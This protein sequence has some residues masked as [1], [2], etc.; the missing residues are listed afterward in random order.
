MAAASAEATLVPA[1]AAEAAAAAAE[2]VRNGRWLLHPGWCHRP[3][4]N[5][6]VPVPRVPG[7][8]CIEIFIC[9]RSVL[10]VKI[11]HLF[12]MSLGKLVRP[13][14]QRFTYFSKHLLKPGS[15][16]HG[17]GSGNNIITNN[18]ISNFLIR[19]LETRT[20]IFLIPTRAKK[21]QLIQSHSD[22]LA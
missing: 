7:H 3:A 11:R 16:N 19:V 15:G 4:V 20:E 18:P 22:A 9:F 13:A 17:S 12:P 21:L 2:A 5:P 10:K 6:Q 1:A 8:I 14:K